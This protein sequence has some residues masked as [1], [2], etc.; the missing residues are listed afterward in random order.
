MRMRGHAIH[1]NMAYVPK[2]LLQTWAERDPIVRVEATLRARGLLD[3]AR[4][5]N[6]LEQIEAELDEAQAFAEASPYP[7][8]ADVREGVYA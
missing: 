8:G 7:E 1:D 6:V 3:D 4:L 5:A 2:E